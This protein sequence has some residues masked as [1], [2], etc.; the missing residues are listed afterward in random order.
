M[1]NFKPF[2]LDF[3]LLVAMKQSSNR[4]KALTP[5]EQPTNSIGLSHVGYR[6][7]ASEWEC[8]AIG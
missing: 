2:C 8:Y 1:N 4:S 5:D 3:N 7:D 6:R